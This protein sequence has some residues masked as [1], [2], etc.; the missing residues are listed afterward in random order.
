[1][2]DPM[3]PTVVVDHRLIHSAGGFSQRGPN[4]EDYMDVTEVTTE[5]P[6]GLAGI[7]KKVASV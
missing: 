6:D 1:M 3:L 7:A 5:S 4:F 2:V